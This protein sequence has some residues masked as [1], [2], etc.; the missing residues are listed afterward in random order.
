MNP[1]LSDKESTNG[2]TEN[3]SPP[4][5]W[6]RIASS[7]QAENQLTLFLTIPSQQTNYISAFYQWQYFKKMDRKIGW[8]LD[9]F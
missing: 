4:V 7:V 8:L 9:G 3:I 5:Y 6:I 1:L 2:L